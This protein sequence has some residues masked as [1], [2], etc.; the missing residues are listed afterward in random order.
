MR[1]GLTHSV[2]SLPGLDARLQDLGFVVEWQPLVET[3]SILDE[4]TRRQAAALLRSDWL[5]FPSRSAVRAWAELGLPLVYGSAFTRDAAGVSEAFPRIAA[6]GDG[7]AAELR[8]AGGRAELVGGGDAESTA[9]AVLSATPP[10]AS[11]GLVQGDMARPTLGLTLAAQGRRVSAA[12][13]YRTRTRRWRGAPADVTVLA[14]PSGANALGRGLLARTRC[15]AVGRVTAAEVR[16][17][18]GLPVVAPS[19]DVAG[20]VA[21]VSLAAGERTMEVT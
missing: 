14:S 10:G 6:V 9:R 21:A 3:R 18:G 4:D 16:R 8:I 1:V 5:V 13:V 2:G 15:V 17:L 20:V 11:V 12:T 19:P 7:T